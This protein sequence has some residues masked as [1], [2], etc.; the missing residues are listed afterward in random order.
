MLH[1][2]ENIVSSVL[3]VVEVYIGIAG[4]CAIQN[5]WKCGIVSV[6]SEAG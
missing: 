3:F 5:P 2:Q 4:L 1:K 6:A